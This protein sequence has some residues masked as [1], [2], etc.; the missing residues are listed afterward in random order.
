MAKMQFASE[1]KQKGFG[2]YPMLKFQQTDEQA[3]I[4][5]LETE[6]EVGFMHILRAPR[7]VNGEVVMKTINQKGGGTTEVVEMDFIGAHRCFGR[8]EKLF[9]PSMKD[10]EVCPTCAEAN[11]NDIIGQCER[12]FAL[13]VIRYKTQPGSYKVQEPFQA[14]LLVWKFANKVYDTMVDITEEHGDLRSKD[15]LLKCTNKMYQNVDIQIG[16]SAAWAAHEEFV[17]SLLVNKCED[18]ES[19]IAQKKSKEIAAEDVA[20]VKL[21]HAQAFGGAAEAATSI[22]MGGGAATS[23]G[24][25]ADLDALLNSSGP[26]STDQPSTEAKGE[27]ESAEAEEPKQESKPASDPL[28]FSN[29]L[30]GL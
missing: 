13:H 5:C 6:P 2:D 12:R 10:P 7:I 17:N 9:G 21:R 24:A 3:R 20:K 14:E 11:E 28:D 8:P 29:I 27:P 25:N 18:L 16:G 4:A 30:Q 22:R 15:L 1:N 19:L 26:V 23:P